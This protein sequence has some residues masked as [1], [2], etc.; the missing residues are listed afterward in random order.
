MRK[1]AFTL[2][3]FLLVSLFATGAYAAGPAEEKEKKVAIFNGLVVEIDI[4]AKTLT[5]AKANSELGMLLNT[6]RAGFSS[7]YK[8]IGD[9]KVGDQVTVK[10][11]TKIGTIYALDI[12]KGKNVVENAKQ[13]SPP[14][15]K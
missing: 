2:G 1:I 15:G 10:F 12:A 3:L 14:V 4:K 11:E 6:S 5:V 9:V 7:G 13:P 8:D